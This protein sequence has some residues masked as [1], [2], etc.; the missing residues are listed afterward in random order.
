MTDPI[1][2]ITTAALGLALDAASL[3]QQAI[4]ANIANHATEG[5]VPQQVDFAAQMEE[6]RRTL[7]SKGSLDAA[8]LANVKARLQPMLDAQGLPAKV[9]IDEQVAD[10]A[11]NAAHFQALAKGLSRHYSILSTAVMDGKR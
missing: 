8:S 7:D 3:R 1:S 9:R 2:N 5:Y 11:Q 10:L 6:A 4:A